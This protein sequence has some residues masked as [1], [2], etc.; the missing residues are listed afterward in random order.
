MRQGTSRPGT[1]LWTSQWIRLSSVVGIA[2]LLGLGASNASAWPGRG[3]GTAKQSPSQRSLGKS[4]SNSS[5]KVTSLESLASSKT[6]LGQQSL[7]SST[8]R[9]RAPKRDLS[10]SQQKTDGESPN[11]KVETDA[12]S[13]KIATLQKLNDP[14]LDKAL[15]KLSPKELSEMREALEAERPHVPE[16]QRATR[17]TSVRW[18]NARIYAAVTNEIGNR[19]GPKPGGIGAPGFTGPAAEKAKALAPHDAADHARTVLLGSKASDLRQ[20]FRE[21]RDSDA[22]QGTTNQAGVVREFQGLIRQ[23]T[24][25]GAEPGETHAI[26]I[27]NDVVAISYLAGKQ[28]PGRYS[29]LAPMLD[30]V[31]EKAAKDAGMKPGEAREQIVDYI[32][33]ES[34][35]KLDSAGTAAPKA[36][37]LDAFGGAHVRAFCTI[38]ILEKAREQNVAG[39]KQDG[40]LV[41]AALEHARDSGFAKVYVGSESSTLAPFAQKGGQDELRDHYAE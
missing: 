23:V 16:G 11:K 24:F 17:S 28:L 7:L 39:K 13:A 18:P 12:S 3:G 29:E 38:Q 26:G 5:G 4:D 22:H 15:E 32:A 37:K 31:I 27:G 8:A 2:L 21:A 41:E 33:R 19:Q 36:P 35:L 14:Q 9:E 6:T 1:P 30:Q 40:R 10:P 34:G 20:R 25:S